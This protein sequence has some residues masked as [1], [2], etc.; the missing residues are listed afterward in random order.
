MTSSRSKFLVAVAISGVLSIAGTK[1]ASAQET[2]TIDEFRAQIE[3]KLPEFEGFAA[4]VLTA[5]A[6]VAEAR[7]LPAMGLRYEREEVFTGG[8]GVA[9]KNAVSL[10]WSVDISGRRGSYIASAEN[11]VKAAAQGTELGKQ[12]VRVRALRVYYMA[13][14]ARLRVESLQATRVPLTTLIGSLKNRVSEGDASGYDLARFELQL[15]EH[16]DALADAN[17]ELSVAQVELSA[18]LG[19]PDRIFLA[20]NELPLPVIVSGAVNLGAIN[21]SDILATRHEEK[22]GQ[23]LTKAASRWWIPT[24]DLSLGYLN[25]DFGP[26]SGP[27]ADV[28]H[29]YT[30]MISASIPVFSKGDADRKRGEAQIRRA[31][32]KR[33]ILERRM[34][35]QIQ[36]ARTRLSA[37]VQQAQGFKERQLVKA[38]EF[39]KKTEAAYQ[40]G[41]ATTLELR[42]VYSKLSAAQLR[43]IELRYQ[44]RLAQL[45]LWSATGSL[46]QGASN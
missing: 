40:G 34:H 30:G 39:A 12:R 6:K 28:A 5:E 42:D 20:V 37:R 3:G 44:C 24:L 22:S 7:S 1:M 23:A 36:T 15:T 29:G 27:G 31:K 9:L 21:R 8:D 43:F 19:A 45:D 25:T 35:T 18:L 16:D 32:A 2:L 10:A 17:T 4:D 33:K 46:G 26:G 38:A 13:A 41:E 14:Y 11:E